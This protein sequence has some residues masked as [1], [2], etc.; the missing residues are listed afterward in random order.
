MATVSF[1]EDLTINDK[2]TEEKVLSAFK[3]PKD[4]TVKS[5]QPDKLPKNA[6]AVWFKRCEK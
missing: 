2:K 4:K 5:A 3:Q 6:G 1:K